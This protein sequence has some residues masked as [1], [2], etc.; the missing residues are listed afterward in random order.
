[1][2][3]GGLT[4]DRSSPQQSQIGVWISLRLRSLFLTL[5][6]AEKRF[7]MARSPAHQISTLIRVQLAVGSGH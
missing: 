7:S 1:M 6:V 5:V 2:H 4:F 3:Q